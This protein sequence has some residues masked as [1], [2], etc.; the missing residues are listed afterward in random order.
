[1]VLEDMNDDGWLDLVITSFDRNVVIVLLNNGGGT[2]GA[3]AL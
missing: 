1:L 2:F 3:L